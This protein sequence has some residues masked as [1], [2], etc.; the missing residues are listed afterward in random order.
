MQSQFHS[1]FRDQQAA[2]LARRL[3]AERAPSAPREQ[4]GPVVL[5]RSRLV[6]VPADT[7]DGAGVFVVKDINPSVETE[8]MQTTWPLCKSVRP[9]RQNSEKQAPPAYDNAV[10]LDRRRCRW[11]YEGM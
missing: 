6:E 2:H 4:D 11:L 9:S 1:K 7:V 3:E 8:Y 5:P 10:G